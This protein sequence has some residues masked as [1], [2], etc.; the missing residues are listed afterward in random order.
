MGRVAA[1]LGTTDLDQLVRIKC[2]T[3]AL[4]V[5][6][7]ER[8]RLVVGIGGKRSRRAQRVRSEHIQPHAAAECE[9]ACA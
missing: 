3:V 1:P 8:E 2:G 9:Y 6:T 4:R 5:G 7:R